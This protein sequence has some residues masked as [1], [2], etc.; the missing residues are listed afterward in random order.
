METFS[1]LVAKAIVR[2]DPWK[3]LSFLQNAFFLE[4]VQPKGRFDSGSGAGA[5]VGRLAGRADHRVVGFYMQVLKRLV[6]SGTPLD[7]NSTTALLRFLAVL[8]PVVFSG[9]EEAG[10]VRD[11]LV[12]W[13]E[14]MSET[15]LD[16]AVAVRRLLTGVVNKVR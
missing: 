12:K 13:C 10:K 14:T 11:L 9:Q 1:K 6:K 16:I 15:N 8:S 4:L 3:R 5:G 2:N 7:G